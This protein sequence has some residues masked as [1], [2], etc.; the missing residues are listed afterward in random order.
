VLIDLAD[1]S[2]ISSAGMALLLVSG[3]RLRREGI[4]LV[5]A[6]V[7]GRI[8]EVLSLAGFQELFNVYKT[9]EEAL[10]SLEKDSP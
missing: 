2:F 7:D 1:V 6:A 8:Y 5:L 3:K 4:S 9:V 10:T